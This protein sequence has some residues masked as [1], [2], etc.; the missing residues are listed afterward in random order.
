MQRQPARLCAPESGPSGQLERG[1]W[2][3]G[4]RQAAGAQAIPSMR[5]R[6]AR[7]AVG[8]GAKSKDGNIVEWRGHSP[9][10]CSQSNE[11]Q[12]PVLLTVLLAPLAAFAPG[13]SAA[14]EFS[15]SHAG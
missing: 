8:G 7:C 12:P 13:G 4:Q 1:G 10:R 6:A 15:L 3:S 11:Q 9:I 14:G 2:A 5:R